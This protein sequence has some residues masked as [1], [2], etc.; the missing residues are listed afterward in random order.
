MSWAP[1]AAITEIGQVVDTPFGL[2]LVQNWTFDG[3]NGYHGP[4]YGMRQLEDG[5]VE[6][7]ICGWL[8]S[9]LR[10][11]STMFHD[12]T[13]METS[14]EPTS[15]PPFDQDRREEGDDSP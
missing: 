1:R 6:A 2:P 5:R 13:C 14:D 4:M 10:E 11:I 15:P 9:E 7:H 8:I 3:A 12:I